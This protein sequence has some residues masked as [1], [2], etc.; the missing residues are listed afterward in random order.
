MT[1]LELFLI[2][3]PVNYIKEILI[4]EINKLLEHPMEL[5]EFIRW[6]GCWFYMGFWVRIPNRS[7]WWSTAEPKISIGAPF[8]LNKYMSSTRFEGIIGYICYIF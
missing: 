1:K 3:F 2:L 5:G 8:R 4:P 7:N 6:L